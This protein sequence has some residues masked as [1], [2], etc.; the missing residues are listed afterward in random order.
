MTAGNRQNA[1]E[2]G[3]FV[4]CPVHERDSEASSSATRL[5]CH[6]S[7]RPRESTHVSLSWATRLASANG[8]RPVGRGHGHLGYLCSMG[9]VA[10]LRSETLGSGR[11]GSG[12]DGAVWAAGFSSPTSDI[13]QRDND[14]A[15]LNKETEET[16]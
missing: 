3:L 5:S 4:V 1:D 8:S 16:P 15:D 11:E 7:S 13:S 10:P 12:G 14:P 2:C 9:S 6:S